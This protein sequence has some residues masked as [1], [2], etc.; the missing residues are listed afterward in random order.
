[1]TDFVFA[2]QG[3]DAHRQAKTQEYETIYP[4]LIFF[5]V[6]IVRI[7]AEFGPQEQ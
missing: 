7:V 1:M 6:G 2:G 5:S 4:R 3:G